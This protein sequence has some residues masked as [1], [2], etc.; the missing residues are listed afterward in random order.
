MRELDAAETLLGEWR[1]A[2]CGGSG[3]DVVELQLMP[4]GAAPES[5]CPTS[6]MTENADS[7]GSARGSRFMLDRVLFRF[8][9]AD[10]DVDEDWRS[11]D[12]SR[13]TVLMTPESMDRGEAPD[14]DVAL[15]M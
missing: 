1:D 6:P 9:A 13:S 8:E 10:E 14:G 12:R 11:L 4:G 2:E 5:R 3:G 7:V 15:R